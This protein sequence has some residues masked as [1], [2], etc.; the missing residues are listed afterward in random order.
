MSNAY[1]FLPPPRSEGDFPDWFKFNTPGDAIEGTVTDV[2]IGKATDGGNDYAV[3]QIQRADGSAASV[4][5]GATSLARAVYAQ[6]PGVGAM[7]RI[8]FTGFAGRAKVFQ[9]DVAPTNGQAPAAPVAAPSAAPQAAPQGFGNGVQQPWA[10]PTTQ[11]PV[12]APAA[13]PWGQ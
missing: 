4:A 6:R 2:R 10:A 13:P 9:L 12:T 3:L 11:A 5:C 7:V 8:T 1:D